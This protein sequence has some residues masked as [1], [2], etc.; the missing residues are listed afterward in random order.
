[1]L[2]HH[3]PSPRYVDQPNPSP[4]DTVTISVD[5]GDTTL[6]PT[7]GNAWLRT[8]RDGEQQW[9]P[10]RTDGRWLRFELGCHQPV[11]N[12]RIHLDTADGPRW[13]TGAGLLDWDP[14]DLTD[15]RLL[16]TGGPPP[17]I[18]DDVWYQ[19]FPDRFAATGRHRQTVGAPWARWAGWDDPVASGPA[20]MTQLYGGDLD[21][22]RRHLDH[23]V[24][25][26][27]GGIYL[28]PVFPA[29][30]N[31]RYNA[32]SF[33]RVDPL[34]GGDQALI[35]L[36]NEAHRR[37]LRIM[38]DLTLNHTGDHHDWFRAARADADS[39]EAGFYYFN[40]H[41]DDYETWLGIKTLP[42]LDHRNDELRRRLHQGPDSVLARYLQPPFDLDGWRIDVANMTGRLGAIDLNREVARQA[43][44]TVEA[45]SVDPTG[46]DRRWLVAEHFFDASVDAP[47]D[48]WH[49]VMNY[50]GVTRPVVSWLGRFE[51]LS[52]FVA[53][54]GQPA[55]N[56]MQ[57][58][59]AMDAVRASLP[60]A[61]T[62][63]SMTLLSSHDTARWRS[64]AASDDVALVGFGLLMCL[65]GTPTF[66]Y[67]DEIGL[68]GASSEQSRCPMPWDRSR[69]DLRFLD[70][71][72]SLISL[73]CHHEALRIGGFRW[74]D[75]GSEAV[76]FLRESPNER[77]LVRAARGPAAT[78]TLPAG[79]LGAD[80]TRLEPILNADAVD[81]P[82]RAS[83]TLPADGPAISIWAVGS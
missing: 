60:W 50:A 42:K 15:F 40:R 44:A 9:I 71:Y 39:I 64:M 45:T 18:S 79:A 70:W 67:G 81:V 19:I 49:G 16:T 28:T 31:H 43:R 17:W 41:P 69:W 83:V 82:A 51:T 58:A 78:T 2:P 72:R 77:L 29:P 65:P 56:G 59:K 34:L 63:G 75:V 11:V 26:G 7:R 37:G 27:V 22:V 24:D 47:G 5:L 12:Y 74:V 25:L 80:V 10:G 14:G 68:T 57:M 4:G 35:D 73:R 76:V 32:S 61:V 53:G 23:L 30:S 20:A 8:V 21:G 62:M 54:P 1:M 33:D 48:G 46:S 66:F 36:A 52:T 3:D 13:L 6:D 38:T 55:R